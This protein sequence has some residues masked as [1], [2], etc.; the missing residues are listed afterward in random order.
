LAQGRH[1]H[2][3][4]GAL[5]QSVGVFRQRQGIR[6]HDQGA[7]HLHGPFVQPPRRTT[8]MR[9]R[10]AP[11]LAPGLLLPAVE[12]RLADPEQGSN[13]RPAQPATLTCAQRT[14]P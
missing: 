10:L 13:P 6:R 14:L 7:Q 3:H 4:A 2:P 1:A 11:A 8:P 9:L 5:G 12:R